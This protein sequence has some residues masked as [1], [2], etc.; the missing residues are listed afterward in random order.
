[1]LIG[2]RD[3]VVR[4]DHH[5][6]TLDMLA[7]FQAQFKVGFSSWPVEA[8][9]AKNVIVISAPDIAPV[10][11]V[12]SEEDDEDQHQYE[13]RESHGFSAFYSTILN[14]VPIIRPFREE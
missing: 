9:I 1:M 14:S 7:R 4:A 10:P 5:N 2:L 12:A 8:A 3:M 11:S 13:P 6:V